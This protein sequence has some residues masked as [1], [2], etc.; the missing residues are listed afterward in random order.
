MTGRSFCASVESYDC[1]AP[2]G[3]RV[4]GSGY[5]RGSGVM[6][7]TLHVCGYCWELVCGPCSTPM[8]NYQGKQVRVCLGHSEYELVDWL[9]L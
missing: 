5:I 8:E 2:A 4:G 7:S 9:R 6:K 1:E 3:F